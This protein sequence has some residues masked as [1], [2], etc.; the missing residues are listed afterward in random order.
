MK[1]SI[2]MERMNDLRTELDAAAK[3][4]RGKWNIRSM[5]HFYD[6]SPNILVYRQKWPYNSSEN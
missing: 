5:F 3:Q 4:V 2:P 6:R 1:K